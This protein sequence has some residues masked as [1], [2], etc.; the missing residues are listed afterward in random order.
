MNA[1]VENTALELFHPLVREWFLEAV[2]RPT[3]IQELAWPEI[4][5][6]NHLLV[7]APTRSGCQPPTWYSTAINRY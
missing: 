1:M 6:G 3:D 7:S 5:G 2:G 4:A